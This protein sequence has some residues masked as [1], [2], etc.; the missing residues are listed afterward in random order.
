MFGSFIGVV[1]VAISKFLPTDE[2]IIDADLTT[3]EDDQ[4][5]RNLDAHEEIEDGL[6]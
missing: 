5:L 1:L 6:D 3:L 2:E 4:L